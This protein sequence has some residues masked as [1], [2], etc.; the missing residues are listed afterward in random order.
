VEEIY[1]TGVIMNGFITRGANTFGYMY[2]SSF[3]DV[4][5]STDV[6]YVLD[7]FRARNVKGIILD[8]RGNTGGMLLN[9]T[10][11]IGFFTDTEKEIFDTWIKTD[12]ET[13]TFTGTTSVAP[14]GNPWTGPVVLLTNR[15]CYSAASFTATGFKAL[16]NVI[17]IGDQTGGG[18][19]LPTGAELPNGWEYR[20][21]TTVNLRA[22]SDS[23]DDLNDPAFN[24]EPGVPPDVKVD[25]DP[26]DES[27]GVDTI[28]EAAIQNILDRI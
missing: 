17:Q 28:L 5:I 25:M 9:V 13:Y 7:R 2:Y 3:M 1:Y 19:G 6:N 26:T 23:I 10:S 22:E 21:S 11:L 14:S 24:Y 12:P 27:S 18:M 16:D 8:I 15:T 20:I 4:I